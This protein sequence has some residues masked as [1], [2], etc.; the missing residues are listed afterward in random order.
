M[1]TIFTN[2]HHLVVHAIFDTTRLTTIQIVC[3]FLPG[4]G[5]YHS[6]WFYFSA[7]SEIKKDKLIFKENTPYKVRIKFRVQKEIVSGLRYIQRIYRG[8]IKGRLGKPDLQINRLEILKGFFLL[9]S[10]WLG[11]APIQIY[12]YLPCL[13]TLTHEQHTLYTCILELVDCSSK[14][15]TL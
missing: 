9:Q 8:G 12:A 11:L 13:H 1:L 10:L 5:S 7:A 14:V 6:I 15:S 4:V 2:R 3:S